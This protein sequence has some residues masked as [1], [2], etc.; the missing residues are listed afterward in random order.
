V[1]YFVRPQEGA[2]VVKFIEPLAVTCPHCGAKSR[3]NSKDLLGLTAACPAC[4]S[5]LDEVGVR[6]GAAVDAAWVPWHWAAVLIE[7]E[8]RLG[9]SAPGIPD[10]DALGSEPECGWTLRGLVRLVADHAP[11]GAETDEEA[12]RVVLESASEYAGR[13]VS[14][15]D[16]DRPLLEALDVPCYAA[17]QR[18]ANRYT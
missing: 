5:P 17:R 8:D 10:G 9:I 14:A 16:L 1:S 4:R 3:H 13:P 2:C 7:V 15:S 12:E 18:R 6:M 11:P